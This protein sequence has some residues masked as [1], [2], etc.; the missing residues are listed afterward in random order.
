MPTPAAIASAAAIA[1]QPTGANRARL[2]GTPVSTIPMTTTKMPGA[3]VRALRSSLFHICLMMEL[4]TPRTAASS[5]ELGPDSLG[6]IA[7][8]SLGLAE[9]PVVLH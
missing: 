4:V 5:P 6:L 3:S 1:S 9:P 2:S 8:L 7:G